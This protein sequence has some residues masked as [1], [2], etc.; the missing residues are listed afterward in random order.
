MTGILK[1]SMG[2]KIQP[3][4]PKGELRLLHYCFRVQL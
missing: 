4:S 3:L 1:G 2:F